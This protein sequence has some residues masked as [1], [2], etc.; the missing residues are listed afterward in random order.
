[1]LNSIEIENS[2]QTHLQN[3]YGKDQ[4]PEI[5]RHLM[6]LLPDQPKNRAESLDLSERDVMLIAYGDHVRR[7]GENPLATL[8]QVLKVLDLPISALHLLPFYPYSSDDG[9]SVIDYY[10]VSPSFGTWEDVEQLSKSYRLMFDVVINHI[11]SQSP[12][13][14]AFLQGEA[15]YKDYFIT[16]DPKTDLSLVVRPRTLPLLSPY[17]TNEGTKHLWTTFSADQIDLNFSNPDVLLELVRLLRFYVEQGAQF[18]RLDAIAFLWKEIGTTS[19]HLPQTHQIIQLMRDVLDWMAPETIILTETN[20]PHKENI[21]Y[22]GNGEN[23]AQLVYQFPLPPLI[24]HSMSE[25]NATKLSEW[26]KGIRLS[27]ERTSFFNF[28]ASHDGIGL[29]PVT[30]IL[31]TMEIDALVERCLAHG[32]LVSYRSQSDGTSVPYE[33]NINYFDAINAPALTARDIDTAGARFMVSQAIMLA[34]IGMPAIYFHSIVGSQNDIRG[35]EATGR[36]RSINREKL[37]ADT[38]LSEIQNSD[39]LRAKV[40]NDYK[41]LLRVRRQ[42]KAFHPLGH[43]NVYDLDSRVFAIERLSPDKSETILALHNVS[44]DSLKVSLPEG[45]W[46]NLLNQGDFTSE[47]D[48]EP[49]EVAWL[50]LY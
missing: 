20:V 29:R 27:S 14:Q 46:Q 25:G 13:F 38:L 36:N 17:E 24:L 37:D 39:S 11:S 34:F 10:A 21:S 4:A 42:Q 18:I 41:N 50:R 47:I 3:L 19:I 5:Y 35:Y 23:E 31:S 40:L 9:F 22:F 12:W 33:L 30:G 43:Q 6:E 32:G 16:V 48:L 44:E 45:Q 1:M 2:I 8:D 7:E 49:Y 28:T 26:A 15:P